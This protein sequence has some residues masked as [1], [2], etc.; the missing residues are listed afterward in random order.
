MFKEDEQCMLD[1]PRQA[2]LEKQGQ[3]KLVLNQ[4]ASS[5]LQYL[6]LLFIYS[7][8]QKEGRKKFQAEG[9]AGT[10]P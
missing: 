10:S 2:F 6:L 7:S 4:M 9:R 8:H 3:A 5:Y 1:R